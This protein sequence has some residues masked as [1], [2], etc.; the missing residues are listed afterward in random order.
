MAIP[1]TPYLKFTKKIMENL[2][3]ANCDIY[4]EPIDSDAKID[5]V[6][7]FLRFVEVRF[8]RQDTLSNHYR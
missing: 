6:K 1:I 3:D 4:D 7:K 2:R 5:M 8:L